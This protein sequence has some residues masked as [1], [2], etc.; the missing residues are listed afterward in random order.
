MNNQYSF[1]NSSSHS[2]EVERLNGTVDK[3]KHT[4]EKLGKENVELRKINKSLNSK[5]SLL[6]NENDIVK[7]VK[8]DIQDY[9]DFTCGN[10]EETLKE[11]FYLLVICEKM[12]YMNLCLKVVK[13]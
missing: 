11:F 10:S 8:L 13:K 6:L 12:K 9:S 3:L 4:V 2:V 7:N 1:L 5:L